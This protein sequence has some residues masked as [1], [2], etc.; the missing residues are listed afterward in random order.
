VAWLWFLF[1]EVRSRAPVAHGRPF[2]YRVH[3]WLAWK[4]G[5]AAAG[6]LAAFVLGAP[7]AEAALVTAAILLVS[8][9]VRSERLLERVDW[10][11]LLLFG[12][13]FI[14]TRGVDELGVLELAAN[15][16]RSTPAF[17]LLTAGL[18]NVISN[19]PAVLLLAPLVPPGDE[20]RWLLLAAVSTLAGN[21][22]LLGSVANLIVA[23]AARREGER[24][25]FWDHF[26]F[27]APLAA[28]TCL[29]AAAWL[30]R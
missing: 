25:G 27:G 15:M 26:K 18:S 3:R 24:L 17:A 23:E 8:R 12:G 14:V 5:I 20:A 6:M 2:R 9:R 16:A 1:P 28:V 29:L 10:Q 22:T 30:L 19:V 11:L 7:Y 13:L 4:G 21:L